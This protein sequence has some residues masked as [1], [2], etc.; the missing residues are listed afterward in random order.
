MCT[1]ITKID[2]SSNVLDTK[3]I[4][5]NL[6]EFE[7]DELIYIDEDTIHIR[8]KGHPFLRNICMA[9]DLRFQREKPDRQL[10]SMTI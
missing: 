10:F 2:F 4:L 6:K 1:G 5:E 8:T 9:F 3:N 7:K